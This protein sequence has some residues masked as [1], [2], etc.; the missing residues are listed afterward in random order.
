MSY[1]IDAHAH[2][3]PK[4]IAAKASNNIG[5]FYDLEMRFD[6]SADSLLELGEQYSVDRFVVQSV[7]T[8]PAQV[9]KINNFI[10]D[11]VKA[12]SDKF[13][14]F[15]SLHPFMNNIEDEVDRVISMGLKGIKLHPDFQEF[16]I[17]SK[18]AYKIFEIIEGRL[19]TLIH[20]G[21]SRFSFSN[22][23]LLK[24]VVNDFPKLQIIAAHFGGWSEWD[25]AEKMLTDKDVYVD[26]S[27][28]LYEISPDRAV[29]LINRFGEDKVFFGTDYPMWNIGQELK[30]ID[31]LKLSNEVKEKILYKNICSFLNIKL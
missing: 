26:T 11:E 21:D 20:A 28:S 5:S 29:E 8:N 3:F 1:L 4:K 6:G 27:S 10:A 19:P 16:Q 23:K 15:A 24:Q 30:Y 7:A 25:D 9:Q 17:N 12:H 13:V 14:G 22:P 2:I 31:N 18:E